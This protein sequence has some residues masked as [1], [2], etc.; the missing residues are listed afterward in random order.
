MSQE[1]DLE[2]R[3][4]R[5]RAA[6]GEPSAGGAPGLVLI[7]EWWGLNDDMRSLVDRFAAEG[8]RALA[9]DLY[10][11]R[12]TSDPAVAM[13]LA[14]EL[15]T[16]EAIPLVEAAVAELKSRGSARVG[17]TGFCLG[18]AV[19]LAAA[20]HVGELAACVPFYGLPR[21]EHADHSEPAPILGHYGA[22][23]PMATEERVRGVQAAARQGAGARTSTWN[24]T[25]QVTPSCERVTPARRSIGRA[26]LDSNP[27]ISATA[28][29]LKRASGLAEEH[30]VAVALELAGEARHRAHV[31]LGAFGEPTVIQLENEVHTAAARRRASWGSD[32]RAS[33]RSRGRRA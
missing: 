13:Q 9:L 8:F 32:A 29:R 33:P 31:V 20:C 16:L 27:R 21:P 22:K 15:K 3:N 12:V 25:T 14:T 6:L 7:H 26:R 5:T 2:T 11:G 30:G 24:S 10:G 19:A 17:I 1:V 4:G 23:D 28:P 18:G